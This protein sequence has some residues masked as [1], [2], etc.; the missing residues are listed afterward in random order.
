MFYWFIN[1]FWWLRATHLVFVVLLQQWVHTV[2]YTDR[3]VDDVLCVGQGFLV[4]VVLVVATRLGHISKLSHWDDD[5]GD[6]IES[7]R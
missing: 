1:L 2:I 5:D 3:T 6:S 7:S 4:L